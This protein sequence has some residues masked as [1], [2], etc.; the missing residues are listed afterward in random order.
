MMF[1][2]GI[3][4]LCV[5]LFRLDVR[6]LGYRRAVLLVVG[7]VVLRLDVRSLGHRRA[8]LLVVGPIVLLTLR[9]AVLRLKA[10]PP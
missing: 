3:Q 1:A 9:I 5:R 2:L 8:V 6:S 7:P 4:G 10:P